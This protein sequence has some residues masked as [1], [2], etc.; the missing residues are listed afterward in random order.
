MTRSCI[1]R[2]RRPVA[3]AR[4]ASDAKTDYGA[5]LRPRIYRSGFS[6]WRA[7]VRAN[8][9]HRRLPQ[10]VGADADSAKLVSA[11]RMSRR[12]RGAERSGAERETERERAARRKAPMKGRGGSDG[13][14]GIRRR[15]PPRQR[16]WRMLGES[17]GFQAVL[18]S[19]STECPPRDPLH[20]IRVLTPA[21]LARRSGLFRREGAP[22]LSSGTPWHPRYRD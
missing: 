5:E 17:L 8:R 6:S 13:G 7:P 3:S 10:S 18:R 14:R 21:L 11:S 20:L 9:Q 22:V 12:K 2:S 19:E 15:Q 4:R 16:L 1:S